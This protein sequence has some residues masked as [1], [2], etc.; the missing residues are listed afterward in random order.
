ME[1]VRNLNQELVE[2]LFLFDVY[3]GGAIPE[4]NKSISFRV[5]YRSHKE[6]LEDDMVN[7]IHQD[8]ADRLLKEFDASLPV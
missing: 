8:I 4:G 3:E 2:D 5:T 7:S 1:N 6:T